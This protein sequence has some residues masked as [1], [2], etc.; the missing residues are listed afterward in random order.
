M[1]KAV[2]RS[3]MLEAR[4]A[5]TKSECLDMSKTICEKFIGS[6]EYKNAGSILLY[7]AYNNEVD[8]DLIFEKAIADGKVVAYPVSDIAKGKP[9]LSF[10]I[11]ND[12]SQLTEGYKGIMEPDVSRLL[13]L[14]DKTADVCIIPG[15]AFDK[16]CNRIGYGKGFYDT[17]LSMMRP[18]KM[19]GLAYEIQIADDCNPE[20]NDMALDM[21]I[22][23]KTV[24][25]R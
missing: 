20:E 6:D 14:F 18:K 1:Q 8:T 13:Q 24:Y 19:I 17:Y 12:Q 2:I 3:R 23:D 10:Y 5:L 15:V 4:R 9:V 7:K 21:V 22:T 16:S 25:K 11:I